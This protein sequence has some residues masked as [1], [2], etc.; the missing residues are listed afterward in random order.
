[1]YKGYSSPHW[2]HNPIVES[3]KFSD[4][5]RFSPVPL[6]AF[7][8]MDPFLQDA[9]FYWQEVLTVWEYRRTAVSL[10]ENED[11]YPAQTEAQELQP[12]ARRRQQNQ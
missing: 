9:Y 2:I 7:S 11:D 6:R 1:M 4:S 5:Y 10:P 12:P 3:S 8:L